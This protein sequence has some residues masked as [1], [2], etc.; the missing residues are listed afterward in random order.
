MLTRKM[1]APTVRAHLRLVVVGP[2]RGPLSIPVARSGTRMHPCAG[3]QPSLIE[4][5][6]VS[7]SAMMDARGEGLEVATAESAATTV[8]KETGHPMD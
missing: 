4:V 8:T 5:E 7:K 6:S 1:L 3:G 2:L